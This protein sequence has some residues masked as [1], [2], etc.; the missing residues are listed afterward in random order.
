MQR[1]ER[2]P[3]MEH[4]TI[5]TNHSA[6]TVSPTIVN[7]VASYQ[8]QQMPQHHEISRTHRKIPVQFHDLQYKKIN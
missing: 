7:I 5:G 3:N 6:T 8:S 2:S 1:C 4:E